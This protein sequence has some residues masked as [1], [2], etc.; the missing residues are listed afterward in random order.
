MRTEEVTFFSEGDRIHGLL[1]H[2]PDPNGAG[3]VQGPG[4]LGLRHQRLYARYH[5]T[6]CAA[7]YTVLVIDYRGFGDSEG[8]PMLDPARQVEDIRNAITFL[9][10]RDEVD[11]DRLGLYGHGATGG[12]NAI[13]VAGQ[14]DRIGCVV[15]N[16]A[17]DDGAAWLRRMRREYEWLEYLDRIAEDRRRR[18]LTGESEPVA[19]QGEIRI[20]T[21]ERKRKTGDFKSDVDPLLPSQVPLLSA[22]GVM[23]SRPIDVADRV[24]KLLLI[25]VEGDDVTPAD[26]SVRLYERARPPKQLL[27]QTG[28]THYEA[29]DRYFDEVAPAMVDWYDRHLARRSGL[30]VREEPR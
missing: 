19:P 20:P 15:S 10:T 8:E 12:G 26:M 3:I 28:T 25:A 17:I 9:E 5:E 29:Y 11:S 4:F 13:S 30:R 2:P 1:R 7:G 18:V 24:S 6:F 23:A 27:V 14:D 16:V 22:E 21:P